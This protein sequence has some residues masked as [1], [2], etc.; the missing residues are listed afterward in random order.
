MR[1]S[2][3]ATLQ[4]TRTQIENKNRK[5]LLEG[6]QV[7]ERRM[8]LAG[9]STAIL[10]GGQGPP[11]ILLHGPGE[12][13]TWWI[14][15]IPF[16]VDRYKVII[17]DL[18]G[19][20]A[21]KVAGGTLEAGQVM[22]WIQALIDNTCAEPPTLVGHVLGGAIAARFAIDHGRQI[23]K[24]VLVD[25]LGLGKLRPAL[26]FAFGL[27]RFMMRPT[28]KNYNRFLP[29]CMYDL[30]DL[31]SQLGSKWDPFLA[32]NLEGAKDAGQKAAMQTLMKKLGVPRIPAT[33][34]AAIKV[35]V[36]LVWGRYDKANKLQVAVKASRQFGW[37]LHVIE[38]ARDDPKLERPGAF[39]QVLDKIM[40]HKPSEI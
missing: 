20:G 14:Q 28:E 23:S 12:N 6:L 38:D 22:P 36:S 19:H 27:F 39:V 1:N 11:M 4:E 2:E 26:R 34:L 31:R 33:Q 24:L 25:S 40:A 9:I 29:H 16:L 18:P 32:Y 30:D 21:S 10:E 5:M 35:P 15:A 8:D 17:P 7:T 13:A 3:H 37:P